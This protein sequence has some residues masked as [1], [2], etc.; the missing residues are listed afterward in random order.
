MVAA[1][2]DAAA[3][4]GRIVLRPNR[5]WTWRAN[6]YLFATLCA[7]S[8]TIGGS[9]ALLGLWAVLPFSLLEMLALI[10]C[11][12]HCVRHTHRQEVITFTQEEVRVERGI[13]RPQQVH[14]FPRLWARV[15]V[16]SPRHAWYGTQVTLRSHG[17]EVEIGAFLS[18][19]DKRALVAELRSMVD[20]LATRPPG[21]GFGFGAAPPGAPRGSGPAPRP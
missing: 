15:L 20:A 12:H 17:R 14:V 13:R 6:L 10:A 7:V 18:A 5:S 19:A 21:P 2:F 8:F 1:D 3:R 11:L 4:T 16:A 9:Y